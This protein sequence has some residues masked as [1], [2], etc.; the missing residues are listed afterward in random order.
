MR[1]EGSFTDVNGKHIY[2]VSVGDGGTAL[3]IG[4][5]GLWFGSSP[6]TIETVR[7]DVTDVIIRTKA[8]VNLLTNR[9]LGSLFAKEAVSGSVTISSETGTLFTGSLEPRVYSQSFSDETNGLSLNCVDGLTVMKYRKFKDVGNGTSYKEALE[10]SGISSMKD[11]LLSAIESGCGSVNVWYDGSRKYQTETDIFSCLRVNE[12]LYL[13]DDADSVKSQWEVAEDLLRYLGLHAMMVH[14]D[15]YIF[16]LESVERGGISWMGLSGGAGTGGSFSW[17]GGSVSADHLGGA[18]GTLDLQEVF[19]VVSLTVSPKTSETVVHSPLDTSGTVPAFGSRCFYLTEYAADGDGLNAAHTFFDLVKSHTD[20]GVYD[21]E[22][23]WKD[24]A[25]RVMRNVYWSM[26]TGSGPE[27]SPTDITTAV[28]TAQGA[29]AC[30]YSAVDRLA[31]GPAALLIQTGV[32]DHKAGKGD[33]SKQASISMT[34]RLVISV[35]GNGSDTSPYPTD[36]SIKNAMPLA[37]YSGGSSTS[38]FSPQDA[39]YHSYLVISGSVTLCPL[40]PTFFTVEDTRKYSDYKSFYDNYVR[41]TG[42]SPSDPGLRAGALA[43]VS[44][45]RTNKAGRYLAFEWWGV[46]GDGQEKASGTRKGYIPFTDDGPQEYEYKSQSGSDNVSKFDVLWCMLRI[47]DKVLVEDKTKN[48][49]IDSFT[50]ETYRSLQDCGNDTDTYLRQTFCIGIDPKIGDKIIG[51]EHSIGTNFDYTTGIDATGGMAIPLPYSAGLR[52]SLSLEILGVDNGPWTDY[53]KTRHATMFRHSR[54]RTNVVPIMSHVSSV[55]LND[56]SLKYYT[57]G[58][59]S[60]SDCDIVYRSHMT[61]AFQNEKDISAGIIHSGFT[62]SE[63]S[64]FSLNNKLITSAVS[65]SSGNAVLSVTDVNSG[66]TAKAEKLYVDSLYRHLSKPKLSLTQTVRPCDVDPFWVYSVPA[67]S[68]SFTVRSQKADLSMD[69][70]RVVFA[71]V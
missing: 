7:D 19:N 59:D 45:S 23:V 29:A 33:N 1:I 41:D 50:W 44:A 43:Q 22:R 40:M 24:Y 66:T 13:G 36:D 27:S 60:D 6:V 49:G 18:D 55:V 32:V 46:G 4:G 3:P 54:W 31:S 65:D 21:G 20:P 62:S 48:G 39:S 12:A 38:V 70:S 26:G 69:T 56:F 61:H 30:T 10:S 5:D 52:G 34:T 11:L 28:G 37:S 58:Q 35:N 64:Q 17:S 67:L 8:T 57:D 63:M 25:V 9:Y 47:G 42:I 53:H 14:G 51:E 2:T 71:E 15:V 16:S 68:A